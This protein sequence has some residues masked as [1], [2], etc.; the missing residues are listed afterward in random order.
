MLTCDTVHVSFILY[1]ILQ[2][3]KEKDVVN[4]VN[5]CSK[6]FSTLLE[7]KDLFLGKLPTGEEEEAFIGE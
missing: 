1:V 7:K 5:A 4:A 2:S 6:L 3:E